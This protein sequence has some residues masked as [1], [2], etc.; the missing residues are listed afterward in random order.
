MESDTLYFK[1]GDGNR[2]WNELPYCSGPAYHLAVGTVEVGVTAAATITGDSP[3]QVLNLELPMVSHDALTAAAADAL[4][5]DATVT[6]AMIDAVNASAPA[7]VQQY[8]SSGGVGQ[9][10]STGFAWYDGDAASPDS[11]HALG[12]L[13]QD[14][15]ALTGNTGYGQASAR[16]SPGDD[17]DGTDSAEAW[18]R[19]R[20]R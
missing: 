1:I 20:G 17:D 12:S 19:T 6:A 18:D 7:A 9:F 8:L 10:R 14:A 3:T 11:Y 15:G 5:S 2:S 16:P 13:G 4:A